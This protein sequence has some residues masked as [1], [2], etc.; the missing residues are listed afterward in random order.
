MN[1]SSEILHTLVALL[2]IAAVALT[3]AAF[4]LGLYLGER[5]RRKDAYRREGRIPVDS[6]PPAEYI[7]PGE[8]P[9]R[10]ELAEAP[11]SFIALAEDEGLSEEEAQAEW[12]RLY[13][14]AQGESGSGW[15]QD[16]P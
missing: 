4:V 16:G 3:G 2:A 15:M 8:D 10:P 7:A 1:I 14:Q 12:S 9:G 6:A 13:G 11:P 5:A